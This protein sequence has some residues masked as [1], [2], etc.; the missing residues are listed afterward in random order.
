MYKHATGLMKY[1]GRII[2][3][4]LCMWLD[5]GKNNHFKKSCENLYCGIQLS[6]I[7]LRVC[8]MHRLHTDRMH[9][10]FHGY[11]IK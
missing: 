4:A 3:S 1:M 7:V 8:L 11:K 5:Y 2:I 10:A 6:L 9:D